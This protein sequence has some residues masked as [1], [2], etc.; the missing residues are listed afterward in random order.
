MVRWNNFNSNI[1]NN[2][3]VFDLK[4][5]FKIEFDFWA[6][7][8]INIIKS[9]INNDEKLYAN[10]SELKE[11]FTISNFNKTRMC[12]KEKNS[13]GEFLSLIL[14][15]IITLLGFSTFLNYFVI[16]QEDKNKL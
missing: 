4:F 13:C 9:K 5:H 1:Y 12:V 10:Q 14:G 7:E 11:K 6:L 2:T 15:F 16:Y 3:Q 8:N